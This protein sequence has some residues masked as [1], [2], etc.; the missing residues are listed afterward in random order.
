MRA[1]LQLSVNVSDLALIAGISKSHFW[2]LF[3]Q[4][5]RSSPSVVLARLRMG[6][7]RDLLTSTDQQ[8]KTIAGSLGYKTVS[9]FGRAFYRIFGVSPTGFRNRSRSVSDQ[10]ARSKEEI[11]FRDGSSE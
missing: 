11:G 1:N 2:R 6:K 4:V 8:I 9:A 5:T 10:D 7:A 3:K